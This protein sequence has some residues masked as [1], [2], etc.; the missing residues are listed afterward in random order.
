MGKIRRRRNFSEEEKSLI[1]EKTKKDHLKEKPN[2][3]ESALVGFHG[4]NLN[5]EEFIGIEDVFPD[6]SEAEC[7]GV[8]KVLYYS[9][10]KRDPADPYGEG[11]QGIEKNFYHNHDKYDV[12][13]YEL[14][15]DDLE[16]INDYF[17]DN[18]LG[19]YFDKS[20]FYILPNRWADG[21][22]FLANLQR[23]EYVDVNGN[24]EYIDFTN[25]NLYMW[26][27]LKTLMAIP[28]SGELD[29]VILWRSPTLKVNWRGIIN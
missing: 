22:G 7:F 19:D 23:I 5:Y 20:E 16:P 8:A 26:N 21:S 4:R 11:K 2:S 9:S 1:S 24:E 12:L 6:P 27:D 25:Y 18:E 14:K 15:K 29:R 28:K 13:L 10:D 3:L 17:D